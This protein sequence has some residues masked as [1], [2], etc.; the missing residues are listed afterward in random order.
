MT[1]WKNKRDASPIVHGWYVV[2]RV[3]DEG[4]GFAPAE[5]HG[6][7]KWDGC[8]RYGDWGVVYWWDETF[9]HAALAELATHRVPK[10]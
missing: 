4:E 7:E 8:W 5:W 10:P 1:K 3:A 9:P 6:I 2:W